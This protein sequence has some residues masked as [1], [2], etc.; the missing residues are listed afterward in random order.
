MVQSWI[1][2]PNANN[3]IIIADEISWDGA[4]IDSRESTNKFYRPKL[5]V[6]YISSG[7]NFDPPVVSITSPNDGDE[8]YSGSTVK[9][10]ADANDPDGWITK[11]D[12]YEG[13]NFLG[14]DNSAPYQFNWN[15]VPEGSYNLKAVAFD[16]DGLS[17]TSQIIT[18]TVIPDVDPGL[19][20]FTFRQGKDGYWGTRDAQISE[21]HQT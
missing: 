3:G 18:I 5:T 19:V 2:N 11:V 6:N 9:I 16:N 14:S 12:F 15:N 8:F 13:S 10:E 17:G 4:D 1:N 7:A 20:T 21:N